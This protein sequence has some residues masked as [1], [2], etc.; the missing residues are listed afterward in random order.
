MSIYGK[1]SG[2]ITKE[3]PLHPVTAYGKSKLEAERLIALLADDRFTVTILRP[4]MV[5]GPGAKGNYHL[6]EEMTDHLHLCPTVQN[7]RSLVSI[8]RLCEFIRGRIEDSCSGVFFPQDPNPVSTASL[9]EQIAFEKGKTLRKTSLF[10]PC[11]RFL[12]KKTTIG[13]KAFGDLLYED[14]S[15]LPLSAVFQGEDV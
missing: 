1:N 15:V 12:A 7:R 3:T 14:L 8:D 4:P 10:N 9:I 13:E 6:L 11:I 5:Y 2:T